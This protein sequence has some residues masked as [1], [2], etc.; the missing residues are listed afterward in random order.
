MTDLNLAYGF[1]EQE[2]IQQQHPKQIHL[3]MEQKQERIQSHAQPPEVN[4]QPPEN[5]YL[6]QES[7]PPIQYTN[8]NAKMQPSYSFWDRMNM[9]RSEV[10]K[11]A[12]FSLVIVLAIALDRIGTHYISK[13]IND[14]VFTDMQELLLRAS[15]P[16]T[17]FLI[18]WVV[19]SL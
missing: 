1:S 3:P 18:L 12:V 6:Q 8:K 15:Y 17:V 9:K 14:N 5:I 11:L 7:P 4:Y 13:Y 19:K 2:Q 16:V 10:V